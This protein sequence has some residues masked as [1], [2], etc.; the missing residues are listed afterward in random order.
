MDPNCFPTT[1]EINRFCLLAVAVIVVD[2]DPKG[3]QRFA[4]DS[5]VYDS[6]SFRGRGPGGW[7]GRGGERE[8]LFS[9]V[10]ACSHG[11]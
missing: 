4:D 6:V 10:L 8:E 3:A 7:G 11:K 2:N 5:I 1:L 9:V